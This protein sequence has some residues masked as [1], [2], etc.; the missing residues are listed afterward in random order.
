MGC[1][2]VVNG[3]FITAGHVFE[4][5]PSPTINFGGQKINLT[6][7]NT[8]F[9]ENG[10]SHIGHDFTV[11]GL[12]GIKSPLTLSEELS[13]KES[14]L[15]NLSYRQVIISNSNE[16]KPSIFELEKNL[17]FKVVL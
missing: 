7:E 11:Y 5:V 13:S 16:N 9:N 15:H 8:I 4:E 2:I 3:M 1:G 10:L 12:D 17:N 14:K 6:K